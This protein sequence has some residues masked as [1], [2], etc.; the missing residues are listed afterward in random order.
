MII[1]NSEFRFIVVEQAKRPPSSWSPIDANPGAAAAG[2]SNLRTRT[3]AEL[4][5]RPGQ[6][7]Q[8]EK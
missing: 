6:T 4:P 8:S 2:R 1:T 3:A 7:G 5:G